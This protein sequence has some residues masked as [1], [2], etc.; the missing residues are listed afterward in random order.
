MEMKPEI[1]SEVLGEEIVSK[2]KDGIDETELGYYGGCSI[3]RNY[4]PMCGADEIILYQRT[5][6]QNITIHTLEHLEDCPY[7]LIRKLEN[8]LEKYTKPQNTSMNK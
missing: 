6:P 5:P 2:I 8:I 4:C 1:L 7:T 3:D